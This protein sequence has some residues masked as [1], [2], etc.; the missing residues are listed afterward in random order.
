MLC[1]KLTLPWWAPVLYKQPRGTEADL[2]EACKGNDVDEPNYREVRA[3]AEAVRLNWIGGAITL[4]EMRADVNAVD[5]KNASA[6]HSACIHGVPML[7]LL[8]KSGANPNCQDND[9]DYDEL[10]TSKTFGD[11]VE[12]RT[13]LHYCC[14]EGDV[15]AARLLFQAKAD[16]NIQD[17]QFKTPL[18][19]A[20]EEG[21]DA[22][23]VFLL[24]SGAAPD[25]CTLESGMKNS[26][27]MDAAHSGEHLLAE[28]LI[29]SGADV[30]KVGK[31]D[32]TALH[33]AAR[34]GDDKMVKMLLDAK[35]DA[36]LESKIG[37][38]ISLARKKGSTELLRLLGAKVKDMAT[39][40]RLVF[41]Y[42]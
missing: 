1:K 28:K 15:E 22:V 33:L 10:W 34:R 2:R 16:L 7:E 14:F 29:R 41:S 20:I 3:L 35:A 21:H 24:Q 8:L 25:M 32:M 38:A 19:L 13:P 27:L 4:I 36:T 11:K 30:N 31:Q 17:A 5:G 9:P 37:T 40:K 6:I 23:I 42:V 26:P 39:P 12:H 18:H